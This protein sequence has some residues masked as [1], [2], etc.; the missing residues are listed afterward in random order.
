MHLR[1]V[2]DLPLAQKVLAA[3]VLLLVLI[4]ALGVHLQRTMASADAA[5]HRLDT[6][7][8]RKGRLV[9]AVVIGV[10]LTQGRLYQ[11]INWQSAGLETARLEDLSKRITDGLPDI[12]AHLRELEALADP[13]EGAGQG[14]GQGQGSGKEPGKAGPLA[15]VRAEAD[16]YVAA[17]AQAL[18][19][20]L[21]DQSYAVMFMKA[22]DDGHARLSAALGQLRDRTAAEGAAI[23]RDLQAESGRA[24]LVG[25]AAVG[26]ALAVG[27]A[28]ALL[29]A[30]LIARPVAQMTAAMQ[31]L[32]RGDPAP[33]ATP[34]AFAA[35]RRDEIG[36]MAEALR[37]FRDAMRENGELQ[38]RQRAEA[39]AREE[40]RRSLERLT[41][42]FAG[43]VDRL[44][45]DVDGLALAMK[46][47][48]SSMSSAA[49]ETSG[50][51]LQV[52]RDT[53]EATSNVT[54][55]AAAT[56]ELSASIGEI[57]RQ[58]RDSTELSR[59]AVR[60]ADSS[61]AM[62]R[63]LAESADRIGSVSALI[64]TIAGQ[65]NLLAL[66]ASIEAARAGEHGR[67]FS[68]VAAE[69]KALA[70]QTEGATDQI[71]RQI[72]SV[73][74]DARGVIAVI[75]DIAQTIQRM[76]EI[77]EVIAVS[78]DEQMTATQ[79]ISRS[80]QGMSLNVAQVADNIR[81]VEESTAGTGQ[82][83]DRVLTATHSLAGRFEELKRFV[84]DF[85]GQVQGER[86]E[87]R[88][89]AA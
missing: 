28:V 6:D 66:N 86:Q 83:S 20:A 69:V 16:A 67:G 82:L 48:A 15:A 2:H 8:H 71:T 78:V 46:D 17:V 85:V 62:I 65:T 35:G 76:N 52:S 70:K 84:Q 19:M 47:A 64:A 32:S 89:D 61:A 77:A 53:G 72:G 3:P 36:R 9:D 29:A 60:L 26:L 41:G 37:V 43:A 80:A 44:I 73:Q 38:R 22:V 25:I 39:E 27:L 13:A 42:G 87:K 63:T 50:L 68:I 11:L 23:A 88:L 40:R 58:V 51:S 59:G 57:T 56:E 1:L 21:V 45:T 4:M 54:A 34:L 12:A 24:V 5:L 75:A 49:A 55:I 14:Q 7:V 33:L 81:R 30:R 31:G 74:A 10:G 79:A 18:E